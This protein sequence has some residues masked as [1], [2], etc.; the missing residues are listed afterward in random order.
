MILRGINKYLALESLI[1]TAETLTYPVM[2]G[3]DPAISGRNATVRIKGG[4]YKD[5]ADTN[6]FIDNLDLC[7]SLRP[8]GLHYHH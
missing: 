7:H 8:H 2:A 4:W 1:P 3:L 5:Q 6:V